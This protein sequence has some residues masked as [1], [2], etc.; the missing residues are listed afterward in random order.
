[1]ITLQFLFFSNSLKPWKW[2]PWGRSMGRIHLLDTRCWTVHCY[3]E[4]VWYHLGV[5]K[6][7]HRNTFERRPQSCCKWALSKRIDLSLHCKCWCHRFAETAQG[8]K[9]LCSTRDLYAAGM[10]LSRL[11]LNLRSAS[12][13]N[14]ILSQEEQPLLWDWLLSLR[15][16]E[17]FLRCHSFKSG[18]SFCDL[19]AA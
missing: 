2:L 13:L 8:M 15:G 4:R 6:A 16:E 14:T 7:S 11:H 17:S 10:N 12:G 5:E 9:F 3:I 1:M 19:F 18:K